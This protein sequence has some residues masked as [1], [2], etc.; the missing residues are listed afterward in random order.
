MERSGAQVGDAG[1]SGRVREGVL[2]PSSGR[3]VESCRGFLKPEKAIQGAPEALRVLLGCSGET[4]C[5][6]DL[7]REGNQQ[8]QLLVTVK[9]FIQRIHLSH[10][11]YIHIINVNQSSMNNLYILGRPRWH[12]SISLSFTLITYNHVHILASHIHLF[13][14]SFLLR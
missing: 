14:K 1:V 6:A 13:N 11:V 12:R 4:I 7:R 2:A 8:K 9:S 5:V 3:L 10:T